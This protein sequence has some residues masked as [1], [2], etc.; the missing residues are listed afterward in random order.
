[1]DIPP[2]FDIDFVLITDDVSGA[3]CT[4]FEPVSR[5]CPSPANVIPVNS[6]LAPLPFSILIG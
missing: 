5:F 2:A 6:I 3:A 1:M 4:T